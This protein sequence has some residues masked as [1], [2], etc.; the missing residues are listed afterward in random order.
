MKLNNYNNLLELFLTQ[1]E[2]IDW[3][4]QDTND[5]DIEMKKGGLIIFDELCFHRGSAP[6]KNSRLVLRYLFK[7]K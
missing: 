5:F 1:S 2:F 3:K 4:Q 6:K 7:K